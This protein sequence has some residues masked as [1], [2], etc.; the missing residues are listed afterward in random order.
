MTLKRCRCGEYFDAKRAKLGYN[1]CLECGARKAEA[2]RQRKS[3]CTAPA[4]NKGAYQ[5]VSSKDMAKDVG[6]K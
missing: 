3:R 4:Y 6:K 5:Y 1:F 2:E